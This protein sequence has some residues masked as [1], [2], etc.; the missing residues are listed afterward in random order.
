MKIVGPYTL[1]QEQLFYQ[2]NMTIKYLTIIPMGLIFLATT[3]PS[4]FAASLNK[5]GV[6]Y[7]LAYSV[8]IAM[9]YIPDIQRD[10]IE[11][12]QAQQARGVDLSRHGGYFDATCVNESRP[13]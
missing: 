10:F 11:I 1:T 5:L 9:R 8:A 2:L 12:S 4:E 6:S 7:K 13:D 3:H